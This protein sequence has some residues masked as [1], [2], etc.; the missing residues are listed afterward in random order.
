MSDNQEEIII[1]SNV[2]N[3]ELYSDQHPFR[4][5]LRIKNFQDQS[6]YK[7]FIKSCERLVRSSLEYKMWKNYIIDVLQ[8][9]SCMITNENITDVSLDVHHHIPTLFILVE[10]IVNKKIET[11]EDF[12]TFDIASEAI[13]MHF[14]NRIGYM[15]LSRTIHEK[16][17]S[18]ALSIPINLIR[19]NYK[20]FIDNYSRYLDD[21]DL[22]SLNHKLSIDQVEE[23]QYSWSQDNYP[24]MATG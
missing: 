1:E 9:Q 16:I 21:E 4:L 20:H 24:G 3:L 12:C 6:E 18:S 7:K 2:R 22:D 15:V 11:E 17:H 10:G 23:F 13:K 5:S 8:V 14:M 19:G